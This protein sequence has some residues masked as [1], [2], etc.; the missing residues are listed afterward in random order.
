MTSQ[1]HSP[2]GRIK[3]WV[4]FS[5]AAMG[6][7]ALTACDPTLTTGGGGSLNK[8]DV[9]KVALLVPYG[10][11]SAGDETLARSLENA[12]RLALVDLGTDRIEMTVYNTAG[13]TGNAAAAANQAAAD[14]AKIIVGPLRSDAANAAAVAVRDD[15]LNVLAFSNNASIAGGNMFIL[16]NTFDNIAQRL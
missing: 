15:K 8:G 14:G 12:A 9:V 7:A 3:N 6:L 11:T 10:S 4:R 13:Q 5:I 2:K 1:P 16:G